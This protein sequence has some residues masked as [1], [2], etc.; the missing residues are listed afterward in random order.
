M[1]S[2]N[3]E[4]DFFIFYRK[5][6][7]SL[8][9]LATGL[10]SGQRADAEDSLQRTYIKALKHWSAVGSMA[11]G[12]QYSWMVTTL[13]NEA[14]QQWRAPYR[15]RETGSDIDPDSAPDTPSNRSLEETL[16]GLDRYRRALRKIVELDGRTSEIMILHCISGYEISEIAKMLR[17]TPATVRV[18]LSNGRKRLRNLPPGEEGTTD[19]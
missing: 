19:A 13:I 1:L 14:R 3:Q 16:I 10:W 18:H 2:A 8:F 7:P 12:K 9:R 5:T 11:D 17:I 4:D 15:S 6:S